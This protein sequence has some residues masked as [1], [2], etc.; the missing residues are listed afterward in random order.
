MNILHKINTF[1]YQLFN[2]ADGD[3][4]ALISTITEYY[5]VNQNAP[6]VTEDNGFISVNLDLKRIYVEKTKFTKLIALCENRK[7]SEAYPLAVELVNSTPTDSELNRI[8]GQIESELGETDKAIDSLIDAL[9]WNPK[10]TYALIMMGNIFARDKNDVETAMKYFNQ[11][12]VSDPSDH[13]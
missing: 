7:F 2:V 9:R 10:N 1:L 11:A 3:K 5:T 6:A 12:T 8:K 4:A 13:I